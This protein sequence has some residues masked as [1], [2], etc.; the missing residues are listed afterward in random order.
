VETK[1][2]QV[3]AI[4]TNEFVFSSRYRVWR[5][6]FYWSFHITVWAVFWIVTG[7]GYSFGR[8]VFG[9]IVWTPL[10][11]LFGYPLVYGAIPHLLLKEKI[12]QFFLVVLVWAAAGLFINAAWR[13]YVYVPIQ[14]ALGLKHIY[15]QYGMIARP[16]SYL[17]MTTAVATP[18][19]IK[20]FK[21]W[22]IKQ[23]DLMTAQQG[24]IIAE[25]QLL[26]AQVHPHFLFN[27]LNNIY[28]FSLES[29]PKTP[30]LILKL[31]SLL[32][33]MLYDCKEDEVPLEKELEIMKNY[34]GLERERYGNLIDVSWNV[35]GNIEDKYIA[36]L[37]LLPFLENAFKH[38]AAEQL[39]KPWLSVDI[40]AKQQTLKCKIVNSK[41]ENCPIHRHGIGIEN[42]RKRLGLLY[43]GKHE[44][45]L[46]DEGDFFVVAL[47]IY[48][49]S[50]VSYIPV[51][52]SMGRLKKVVS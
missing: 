1:P 18:M 6:V 21:Q 10:F 24:K 45:R 33:Y 47:T 20:F 25:L 26:K 32:S 4:K 44:L 17:C 27:T 15:A 16:E 42:V 14:Q 8:Q 19:G 28:S 43:P 36:P 11:I 29:S 51:N 30:D 22:T 40:A 48:F 37:M 49:S 35:E 34:I 5:H 52:R 23:R 9:M 13:F 31:S 12:W 39:E 7:S 38:G 3:D 46:N 41:N 2:S 50:P